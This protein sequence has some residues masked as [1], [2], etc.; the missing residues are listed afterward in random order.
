MGVAALR[1]EHKALVPVMALLAEIT[2]ENPVA[3]ADRGRVDKMVR[4]WM[5]WGK[6]DEQSA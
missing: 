5:A 4:P 6:Q 1:H 3:E 2:K